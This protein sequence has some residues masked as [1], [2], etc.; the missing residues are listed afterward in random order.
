MKRTLPT[1]VAPFWLALLVAFGLSGARVYGARGATPVTWDDYGCRPNDP[2]FDNGPVLSRMLADQATRKLKLPPVGTLADYYIQTPIDW[3][4]GQAASLLGSGSYTYSIAAKVGATRIVWNGPPGKPMMIYHTAGGRIEHLILAGGPLRHPD[5][6]TLASE[7]IRIE[8]QV[9]P[10]SSNL[11]TEQLAITQCDAGIHCLDTPDGNHA[12]QQKHFGLLFHHVR[13]PYWVEGR[14]SVNHWLYGVDI[15][16]GCETAFKFDK[17]GV[18]QVFGCY[19]AGNPGQQTLLYVGR[20]DDYTGDYEIHGFQ[21]DGSVKNLRLV[22][23][24]KYVWRVRIDGHIGFAQ[25][26]SDPFVVS[27]DGPSAWNDD[28]RIDCKNAQWPTPRE[29]K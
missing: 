10:P 16:G 26:L 1:T 4:Y 27:R 13:V 28:V 8:A 6:P 17:G 21:A 15:R 19:L 11:Y 3:P 29:K 14:Q 5:Y 24:G 2:A 7:G 18:L 9:S 22:D 12:D 20:A 23:H 25:Q